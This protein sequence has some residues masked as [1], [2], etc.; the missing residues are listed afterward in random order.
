MPSTGA[1]SACEIVRPLSQKLAPHVVPTAAGIAL[2]TAVGY[3]IANVGPAAEVVSHAY[4]VRLGTVGFLTTALFVTHLVMQIP[5][6]VSSTGV[7]VGSWE[8]SRSP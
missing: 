3:N 5:G 7:E 2:G 1:G 8:S 4:G 6:G